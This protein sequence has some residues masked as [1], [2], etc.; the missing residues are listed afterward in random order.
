MESEIVQDQE[1]FA[2]SVLDQSLKKLNEFV[3]IK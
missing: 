1:Y 2:M 3:R